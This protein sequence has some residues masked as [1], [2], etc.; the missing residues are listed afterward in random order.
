VA[1]VSAGSIPAGLPEAGATPVEQP[2]PVAQGTEQRSTKPRGGGSNPPGSVL[3]GRRKRLACRTVSK[4]VAGATRFR[5]RSCHALLRLSSP[6]GRETVGGGGGASGC[7]VARVSPPPRPPPPPPPYHGAVVRGLPSLF[8]I[9]GSYTRHHGGKGIRARPRPWSPQGRESSTLSGA[10]PFRTN[11]G[12]KRSR[13][14]LCIVDL[15][16]KSVYATLSKSVSFSG[17][18]VRSPGGPLKANIRGIDLLQFAL[19]AISE[20]RPAFVFGQPLTARRA[21][22]FNP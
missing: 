1:R 2:E 3:R 16:R 13:S 7:C 11:C 19:S 4:T 14:S 17:V 10:T 6:V 12:P 18:R 9:G 15:W 20:Q 5:V 21:Y 8:G 22:G